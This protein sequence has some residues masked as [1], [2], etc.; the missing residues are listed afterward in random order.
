[1][2]GIHLTLRKLLARAKRDETGGALLI[3]D[4]DGFKAINKTFGHAAGNDVLVG[5]ARYLMDAVR[6]GDEIARLDGDEFAIIM[7]GVTPFEAD[8]RAM[9]ISA[10]LNQLIIPWQERAIHVRGSVGGACFG[11]E[12]DMKSVYRR[13][14]EDMYRRK[15]ER[16]ALQTTGGKHD[17]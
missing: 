9:A 11:P 7:P 2:R 8:K 15:S 12:D 13:A 16:T 3:I 6:E 1:M 17:A 10:G 14:D 4:L 5:V